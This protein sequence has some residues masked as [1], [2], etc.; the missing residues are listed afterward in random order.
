MIRTDISTRIK[1]PEDRS[2]I[3]SPA[4]ENLK[5][6]FNLK[7]DQEAAVE[8]WINNDF[9]G[10]IVYSTGTGKTEIAF[11]CARRAARANQPKIKNDGAHD[12]SIS[13]FKILLLVPRI[14]LIE[15]NMK[16]LLQYGISKKNIGAYFGEK[17]EVR[18][19]TVSTYQSINNNLDLLR[20]SQMIIFDEVHLIG[21]SAKSFNQIF[22]VV[23]ED[24]SKAILGLTATID[25]N[26]PNF[27]TILSILPPVKRYQVKEA[28]RDGRL[29]KP[30]ILPIKVK[31][32]GMERRIY[33]DCSSTITSISNKIN[34]Y[35]AQSISLLLRRGGPLA[36]MAKTWFANVRKRKTLLNCA[37]N[38][39][40][41]AADIISK[42]HPN[43]R[44]MVFSETLESV[45]KLR[46]ELQSKRGIK[47]YVIE[48]KL[49][50]NE[51]QEILSKWGDE[52]YPLLSVHTLEIGYD[53]PE[54][55]VAIILA[56]TSN[57]NQ[58]IQRIGR[59]IRKSDGKEAALIYSIYLT[60]T[61]DHQTLRTVKEAAGMTQDNYTHVKQKAAEAE[62]I[63]TRRV[64]KGMIPLE[65]YLG[66]FK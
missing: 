2:D 49:K 61:K 9:R 34:R 33:D 56:N 65:N 4:I 37:D 12:K 14:V 66:E 15:Q 57:I 50:A 21:E 6:P 44:I 24:R 35:D 23:I 13:K 40:T 48:S 11:E 54:V 28:V 1:V 51:R 10:S 60:G 64:Q 20:N 26:D 38:K 30:V 47:S 16:R 42:K 7:K 3:G 52:F 25:D 39:I 19:I 27:N 22:D 46:K 31:L 41:A 36:F 5:F 62:R 59:V 58:T 18:E 63:G 55:G 29:A 45:H 53:V 43:Q 8:A 17:K 32:T